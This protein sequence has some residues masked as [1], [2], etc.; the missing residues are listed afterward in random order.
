[1]SIYIR[2]CGRMHILIRRA[3]LQARC[4]ALERQLRA[5]ALAHE[6]E[7]GELRAQLSAAFASGASPSA[8]V[9]C[10]H[11]AVRVM[12]RRPRACTAVMSSR[13]VRVCRQ[14]YFAAVVSALVC[15]CMRLRAC[16]VV[17][18]PRVYVCVCVKPCPRARVRTWRSVGALGASAHAC[19][20]LLEPVPLR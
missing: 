7:T 14:R 9:R 8:C 12:P 1:M 19:R 6:A 20:G 18:S 5:S 15:V 2:V 3:C 16:A 4:E 10:S 11:V 13:V 17:V